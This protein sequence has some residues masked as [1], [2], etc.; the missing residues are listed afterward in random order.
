MSSP[1]THAAQSRDSRR[2]KG[3]TGQKTLFSGS[4]QLLDLASYDLHS[5]RRRSF[6]AT[7]PAAPPALHI[8]PSTSRPRPAGTST[9]WTRRSPIRPPSRASRRTRPRSKEYACPKS[10][11]LA[12]PGLAWPGPDRLLSREDTP[13]LAQRPRADIKAATSITKPSWTSR[14]PLCCTDGSA[15]ASP[16]SSSSCASFLLRDGIS[17]RLPIP[18]PGAAMS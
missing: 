7:I 6:I 1:T 12:W 10:A 14:R 5:P 9:R 8:Y 2:L 16:C 13:S 11:G 4:G 3:Q 15:P 17:V 18:S